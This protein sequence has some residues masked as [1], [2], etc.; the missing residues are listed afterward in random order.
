MYIRLAKKGK[1]EEEKFGG[2]VLKYKKEAPTFLKSL[3]S[4]YE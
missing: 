2:R 3:V 1:R 4:K